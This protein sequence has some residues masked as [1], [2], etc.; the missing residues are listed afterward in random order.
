MLI[1][2]QTSLSKNIVQFCRYLRQKGF[3]LGVQ[4]EATALEALTFIDY[5]NRDIFRLALKSV[6]CKTKSQLQ[7]FEQLFNSYWKQI[8]EAVDSKVKTV[9]EQVLKPKDKDA[10]FKSLKAWL[11]GNKNDEEEKVA[12]YSSNESL[13][14]KN[15]ANIPDDEID[16]LLRLIKALS[17]KLAAK[18]GR[19][20]EKSNKIN[21]PDLRRTLRRNMRRGGELLELAYRNPKRNRTKLVLICDV[22]RSM[23]LYAGFLLQFMYAF[24]HVYRRVETFAFSTSLHH[25]TALLRQNDFHD[26]LKIL[27]NKN[28]GW[29]G[30]TRIG[31]SL[32]EFVQEFAPRVID[33][34]T[35][36]IMMSDGWDAGDTELLK[37]SMERIHKICR[38]L[39][40]L[41]PLAGYEDYKPQVAGMRAALPFTDIFAAVHNAESLKRLGNWL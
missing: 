3:V 22:S 29:N 39:I 9:R 14:K 35:I 18:A 15:F 40:W 10:S 28:E 20:Y 26:A 32:H 38:K 12:S 4:D 5:S 30:G 34:K 24:Q 13:S 31:K 33:K 1:T 23:E 25:I 7:E 16:E 11:N 19:R 8:G 37:E 2:R 36:V 21:L 41:N 17:K 6:L 27:S